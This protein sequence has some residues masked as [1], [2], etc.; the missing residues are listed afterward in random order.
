[1]RRKFILASD[2]LGVLAGNTVYEFTGYDYGL[3]SDDESF[4]G[5]EHLAVTTNEDGSGPFITA[6]IEILEEIN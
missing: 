5:E 4:T 2:R 1:M 6:P 3:V